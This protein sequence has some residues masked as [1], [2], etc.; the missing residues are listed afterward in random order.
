MTDGIFMSS[1]GVGTA[2]E[3]GDVEKIQRP[4][5]VLISARTLESYVTS[6]SGPRNSQFEL[7][8]EG[9]VSSWKKT[10]RRELKEA[11]QLLIG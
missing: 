1:K 5:Y 10:K 3:G 7:E 4:L 2:G 9:A 11:K 8:G 6:D